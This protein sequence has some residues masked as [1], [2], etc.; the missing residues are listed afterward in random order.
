MSSWKLTAI[1]ES[2]AFR[3]GQ[4]QGRERKKLLTAAGHVNHERSELGNRVLFLEAGFQIV[5]MLIEYS[6]RF[7]RRDKTRARKI[8]SR[9]WRA[10]V[11]LALDLNELM[12]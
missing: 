12:S 11:K 8:Y 10:P 2:E 9:H 5:V 3:T 6:H 7:P 4:L 1:G